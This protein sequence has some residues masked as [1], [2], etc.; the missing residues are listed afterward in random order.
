VN[1]KKRAFEPGEGQPEKDEPALPRTEPAPRAR[2]AIAL[3]FGSWFL[4]L[5]MFVSI[6]R[7]ALDEPATI[8]THRA[9][10][11]ATLALFGAGAALGVRAVLAARRDPRVRYRLGVA[12]VLL[13]VLTP[14]VWTSELALAWE[15]FVTGE[16]L[17]MEA[18][19]PAE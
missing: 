5:G 16:R 11:L 12:A 6:F 10:T 17:R 13:A 18:E 8:W 19:A 9:L 4:P 15:T 2:T 3:V 14:V 1:G 7:Y